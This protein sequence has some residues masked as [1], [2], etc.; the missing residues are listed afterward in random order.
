M[1]RAAG[2]VDRNNDN[3]ATGTTEFYDYDALINNTIN[4]QR[5]NVAK[6]QK[7]YIDRLILE[8]G[9]YNN[10]FYEIGNE[11]SASYNWVSY[12]VDYVKQKLSVYGYNQNIPITVNGDALGFEPLTSIVC[13]AATADNLRLPPALS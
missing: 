5:L 2:A 7:I 11:V 12:W 4:T 1:S 8:S 10:V 13:P 3:S 6:Y 9:K